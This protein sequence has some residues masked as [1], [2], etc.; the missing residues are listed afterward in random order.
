MAGFLTGLISSVLQL[1]QD[2]CHLLLHLL[3]FVEECLVLRHVALIVPD[4]GLQLPDPAP[5][6]LLLLL[7]ERALLAN[8]HE[9]VGVDLLFYFR[10]VILYVQELLYFLHRGLGGFDYVVAFAVGR[11]RRLF[12]ASEQNCFSFL[13]QHWFPSPGVYY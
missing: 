4:L 11:R 5:V 7:G 2:K 8:G 13:H 10:L 9:L 3:I 1:L 6:V 12:L